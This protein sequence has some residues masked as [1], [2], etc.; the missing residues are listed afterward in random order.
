MTPSLL[1]YE[2]IGTHDCMLEVL[3]NDFEKEKEGILREKSPDM[4][5]IA[6]TP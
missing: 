1:L 3:F 4:F 6:I 2:E 5:F